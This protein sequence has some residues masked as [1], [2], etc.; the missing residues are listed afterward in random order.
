MAQNRSTTWTTLLA[1]AAHE[2]E[3][4]AVIAGV[5]YGMDRIID[6][7]N[8]DMPVL[9]S[10]LFKDKLS[11]GNTCAA[12]HSLTVNPQGDIPRK[13]TVI[14][15]ARLVSGDGLTASEWMPQGTFFIDNP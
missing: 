1:A 13:A 12:T 4:K 10:S 7:G 3:Y 9:S 5:E 14:L 8:S 11:V 15:S 6:N 2:K